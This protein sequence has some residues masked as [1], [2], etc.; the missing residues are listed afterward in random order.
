[1][2][3]LGAS[4]RFAADRTLGRLARWLR[5]L[6]AD[7]F[8]DP[9]LNAAQLLYRARAEQRILLTRDKR[10]R[11]A[12]DVYYVAGNDFRSQLREVIARFDFD[13]RATMLTRCSRC[14][15]AL[16]ITDRDAV[17]MRVP[18][19]VYASQD[20]FAACERC[21]HIYWNAT[22]PGRIQRELDAVLSGDRR[23]GGLAD[24][25]AEG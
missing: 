11:T 7:V 25:S 16:R 5:L 10:L 6:G 17:R 13:P 20:T 19:F 12:S 15:G 1:M 4:P 18:P 2:R 21:G 8:G 9:S 14:N 24:P 3:K 23:G 22:H